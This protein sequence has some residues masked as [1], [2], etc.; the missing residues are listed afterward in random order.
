MAATQKLGL[1][2]VIQALGLMPKG[3]AG[4]TD[5]AGTEP[6][7]PSAARQGPKDA[8]PREPMTVGRR[9]GMAQRPPSF[10]DLLPYVSYE[11]DAKTFVLGDGTTLGVLFELGAV[12]IEV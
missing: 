11:A 1:L 3:R 5:A 9:Q 4:A 8:A 6:K 10:T 7:K 2:S 12:P